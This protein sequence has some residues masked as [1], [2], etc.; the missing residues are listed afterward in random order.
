[1]KRI[2]GC[3]FLSLISLHSFSQNIG[4]GTATPT[5]AKLE[6]HGAVGAT[7]AIFGGNASGISL[8]QNA[9][10]IGFNQ[11]YAG[12]SKYISNG[13]GAVQWFDHTAGYMALD[14]FGNGLANGNGVGGKRAFTIANNG[15]IGIQTGPANASLYVVKS[16]NFDGS[17]IFGGSSYNSNFHY[18]S[19]EHTYIRAGKAGGN[20]YLNDIPGGIVSMGGG[21]T[22][23]GI[24]TYGYPPAYTLEVR[25]VK[26]TSGAETGILLV[27]SLFNHWEIF[28]SAPLFFK[29]NG[30][31]KS[32]ID[33]TDG[34]YAQ[35]SD[36]R[37]KTDIQPLTGTLEKI[38]KLNPVS[39]HLKS[40]EK[41]Q[42]SRIGFI[43]QEVKTL[44]P[45]MVT[46]SKDTTHG[47]KAF[48]DLH[49]MDYSGFG[50]L[51]IKA[52][53]EQQQLITDL[54]KSMQLLE[55]QNKILYQLLNKK[56]SNK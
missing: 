33:W 4:I 36:R 17:A 54:Q 50:V 16:T 32:Y 35:L 10:G 15:N 41:G 47:Y 51:A 37:L 52:I 28:N 1:M 30:V 39:Y 49:M 21:T 19:A 3:Y 6:L 27:N 23:V 43:A 44:F 26:E 14:M 12:G 18:G 34:R 55:E 22:K 31:A 24:N 11:Y 8:Q 40:E 2:L 45:G 53:Q 20:L 5:R 48:A 29:Y 9:P 46:I 38:M 42:D 7:T 25:Q 56:V 13:Y